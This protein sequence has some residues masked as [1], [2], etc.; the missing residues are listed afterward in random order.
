MSLSPSLQTDKKKK[1]KEERKNGNED[2]LT[3]PSTFF[4][5]TLQKRKRC[6]NKL[7]FISSKE[8]N[9]LDGGARLDF[10]EALLLEHDMEHVTRDLHGHQI[11]VMAHIMPI[12]GQTLQSS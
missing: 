7:C 10:G 11:L 2:L 8:V 5:L 4:L 1:K 12:H 6:F 9:E 3:V